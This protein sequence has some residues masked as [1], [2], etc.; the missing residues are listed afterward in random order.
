MRRRLVCLVLA[1]PLAALAACGGGDVK[2]RT[3]A[4]RVTAGARTYAS[5]CATCHGANLRGTAMGPPMIDPVFA[6]SRHPDAAFYDAVEK[7]VQ[8]HGHFN[9][10]YGPM[11]PVLTLDRDDIAN[12]IA[13]VRSVQ[14]SAGIE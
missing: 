14:R 4:E 6:S 1:A 8:P 10:N 3:E 5:L 13:F 9:V 12:V 2:P 11:P 7:G